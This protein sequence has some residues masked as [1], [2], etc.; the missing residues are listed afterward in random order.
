MVDITR[1]DPE[2][3][4]GGL[5]TAQQATRSWRSPSLGAKSHLA[6]SDWSL[7]CRVVETFEI[8]NATTGRLDP[9]DLLSR[10]PQEQNPWVTVTTCATNT[11]SC[12]S[13]SV[14]R[15]GKSSVPLSL[16]CPPRVGSSSWRFPSLGLP[17]SSPAFLAAERMP[18]STT[19]VDQL[20]EPPFH[21]GSAVTTLHSDR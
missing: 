6:R 17:R 1:Y 16:I 13:Q 12:I 20:T 21:G 2:L 8:Q 9:A 4:V 19:F 11:P 7:G 18:S 3:R 14:R 5:R 15:A 10:M